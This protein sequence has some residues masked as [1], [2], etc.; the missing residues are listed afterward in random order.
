[1]SLKS[2][3]AG[4]DS[5]VSQSCHCT[6]V[7]GS[8]YYSAKARDTI[9]NAPR[10]VNSLSA[11]RPRDTRHHRA[12]S[13][14]LNVVDPMGNTQ[15]GLSPRMTLRL[16]MMSELLDQVYISVKGLLQKK[17]GFILRSEQS[18]HFEWEM[19]TS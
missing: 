11:H 18:I 13:I 16:K 10:S 8:C 9:G 14:F 17:T 2:S 3:S 6:E 15:L 7:D 5:S 4:S 19:T 12:G 1:L